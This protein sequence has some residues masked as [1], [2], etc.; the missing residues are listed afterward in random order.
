MSKSFAIAV[1]L[2]LTI[3]ATADSGPSLS[4]LDRRER[5]DY[6]SLNTRLRLLANIVLDGPSH[7]VEFASMTPTQNAAGATFYTGTVD[8]PGHMV[9]TGG[10]TD[11]GLDNPRG[12]WVVNYSHPS[13]GG[14]GWEAGLFAGQSQPTVSPRVYVVCVGP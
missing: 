5:A 13:V 14:G 7:R 12:D 10:G 2:A 8:C 6:K 3:T 1:V 9:A 11:W 4:G